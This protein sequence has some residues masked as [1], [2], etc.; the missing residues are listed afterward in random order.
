M[1]A[2]PLI[3]R[4]ASK[5]LGFTWFHCSSS[6]FITTGTLAGVAG[7]AAGAGDIIIPVGD[8]A[9]IPVAV[10]VTGEV[11][12]LVHIPIA[13]QLVH[14]PMAWLVELLLPIEPFLQEA[15]I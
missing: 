7:M 3:P 12:G 6:V 9:T 11:D 10:E 1:F 13:D 4:Y 14:V 2:K 15:G 8:M 5:Q